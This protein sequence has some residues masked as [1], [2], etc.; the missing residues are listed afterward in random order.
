VILI[1][2][3]AL[4]SIS[5]G[6]EFV[7]VSVYPFYDVVRGIGEG[8]YSTE[9][10]IPPEADYHLYEL[11]SIELIKIAKAEIVFIS[12]V[13]LG[14]WERKVEAVA[15]AKAVRLAEGMEHEEEHEEEHLRHDPHLWMS[16]KRMLSVARNAYSGFLRHDPARKELYSKNLKKVLK[17]LEIL[18]E[19]YERTLKSCKYRVLPV[20]HPSL[21]Y[22]AKDY[23]LEEIP[24]GY[25]SAHGGISPGNLYRFL[26]RIKSLGIDYVFDIYRFR[27]KVAEVL[28]RDHGFRVYTLNVKIVPHGNHRDYFSIMEENLEV[29]REAL[30]CR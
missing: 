1:L 16:P 13:S 9:V 6:R 4:I 10:L 20:V 19:N 29:L 12:G 17:K 23:G 11:S 5:L 25:G 22:L 15:K 7:L 26:K 3:L 24:I 18:H 30:K 2:L 14:G 28:K 21:S 27:T 8:A